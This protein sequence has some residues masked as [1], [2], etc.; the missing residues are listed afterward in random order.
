MATPVG[1]ALVIQVADG[2]M[3]HVLATEM[4][5]CMTLRRM[6]GFKFTQ[7]SK[8]EVTQVVLSNYWYLPVGACV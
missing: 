7:E 2:Q 1:H 4:N 8:I 3:Y 5:G 6:D